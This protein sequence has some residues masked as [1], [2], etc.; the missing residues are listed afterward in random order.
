MEAAAAAMNTRQR[1]QHFDE[2]LCRGRDTVEF[3]EI[4]CCDS[5]GG[6]DLQDY[7]VGIFGDD[8]SSVKA[9]LQ[10][11]GFVVGGG[12][13]SDKARRRQQGFVVGFGCKAAA[14]KIAA[15]AGFGCWLFGGGGNGAMHGSGGSCR[16]LM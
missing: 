14:A 2:F 10:W 4:L 1:W 5:S 15:A 8:S 9:R 12:S 7:G 16:F 13:Y 11:Q 6:G 3:G